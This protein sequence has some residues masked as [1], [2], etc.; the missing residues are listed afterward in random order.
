MSPVTTVF[1]VF[2]VVAHL[3]LLVW[4]AY[5]C[6]YHQGWMDNNAGRTSY[7]TADAIRSLD[8]PPRRSA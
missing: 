1:A 7:R 6:G 8:H 2:G 5:D 3:V 4:R